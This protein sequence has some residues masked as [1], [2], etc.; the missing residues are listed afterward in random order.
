MLEFL[1]GKAT[2]IQG[3]TSIP[4]SRVQGFHTQLCMYQ[5]KTC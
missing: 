2:F 5:K 3:D 4:D 1:G